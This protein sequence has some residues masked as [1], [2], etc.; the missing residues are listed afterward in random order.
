MEKIPE[1]YSKNYTETG[2]AIIMNP[3]YDILIISEKLYLIKLPTKIG[4]RVILTVLGL[5]IYGLFGAIAGHLLGVYIENISRKKARLF[6]LTQEGK[7]V[8][9]NFKDNIVIEIA[10]SDMDKYIS[11]SKEKV[12]FQKEDGLEVNLKHKKEEISRLQTFL[13]K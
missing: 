11:F 3:R 10:L 5:V 1:F 2:M 4:W 6:W 8:S 13:N 12:F 7:I 9:G